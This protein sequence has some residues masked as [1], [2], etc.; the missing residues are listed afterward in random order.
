LTEA[1]S[2][3]FDFLQKTI[4]C[5]LLG[6]YNP[7]SL[8]EWAWNQS[9]LP[10][11]DG[12]LG[13][14]KAFLTRFPAYLGSAVDC[15]PTTES[16]IP[17]WTETAL[18]SAQNVRT[19]L[20]FIQESATFDGQDLILLSLE[21][22][23]EMGK[24]KVK[25]D[26]SSPIIGRQY[27]LSAIMVPAETD[28]LVSSY[29]SKHLS[30]FTSTADSTSARF[31]EVLPK[32]PSF[33]F[34]PEAY[35]VLLNLR[36]YLPQP[37]RTEGLRCDCKKKPTVDN[38]CFHFITGC[39]KSAFGMNI[40]NGVCNTLKE[41]ANAVG[42]RAKREPFGVF[43]DIFVDG[44][45]DTQ[46]NMRPDLIVY[47]GMGT[48]VDVVLDVS[49]ATPVPIFGNQILPIDAAKVP[50]RVAELRY[51]EKERKYHDTATANNLK[52]IPIVFET[53]GRMHPKSLKYLNDHILSKYDT[54][55]QEGKLLKNF[56]LS[57]IS[58]SFQHQVAMS[59]KNKLR[60]LT[61]G[62]FSYGT[63]E[64]REDFINS[65]SSSFSV[66]RS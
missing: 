8:P 58:C 36:L 56:W 35:R 25:N 5:S 52:F 23:R 57:K 33:T 63:Y 24:N 66:H 45:T 27:Q 59:I 38:N 10:T 30:W 51:Q 31:L 26:P 46:Q 9:C 34:D 39:P 65:S 44:I 53:T 61:A 49:N 55:Y 28:R 62:R 7:Q 48:R 50:N 54:H 4:L 14:H 22:V 40:H 11:K 64:N 29:D 1:F 47:N 37:E 3:E 13:L 18:P 43:R 19:A 60:M 42:L 2:E 6:Q 12:G 32:N 15:L 41:L 20:Q 17:N 16:I 21:E